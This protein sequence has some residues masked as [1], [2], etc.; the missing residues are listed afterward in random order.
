MADCN[1]QVAGSFPLITLTDAAGA[2][3][4]YVRQDCPVHGLV[5]KAD[6]A[7]TWT[8]RRVGQPAA[9]H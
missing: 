4:D 7:Q 8:W 2:V 9:V 6:G 5:T 1:C 3:M